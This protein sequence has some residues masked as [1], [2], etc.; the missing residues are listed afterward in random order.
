[1]TNTRE[2][3]AEELRRSEAERER[4]AHRVARVMPLLEEYAKHWEGWDEDILAHLLADL[5]HFADKGSLDFGAIDR[6]AYQMY[7]EDL[8]GGGLA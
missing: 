4:Q 8:N 6:A 2:E 1:M 5:R 3:N 7:L